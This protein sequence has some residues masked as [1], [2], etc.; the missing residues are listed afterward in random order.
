MGIA[1]ACLELS[2]SVESSGTLAGPTD[3]E[4]LRVEYEPIDSGD[5]FR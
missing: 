1:V 5:V 2:V 4:P 3:L